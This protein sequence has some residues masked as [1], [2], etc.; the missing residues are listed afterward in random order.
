MI[1]HRIPNPL[2]C[3]SGEKVTVID[4]P[5]TKYVR[6]ISVVALAGLCASCAH[7]AP[8]ET[9]T[10]EKAA[11][12]L[13]DSPYLESV[14]ARLGEPSGL[15]FVLESKETDGYVFWVYEDRETHAATINR[16]KVTPGGKL[17][18]QDVVSDQWVEFE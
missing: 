17:L 11:R 2:R 16:V 8:V 5:R 1:E 15:R 10:E 9:F 7:P 14:A 4:C 6:W 12:W 13:F 3:R 18:I